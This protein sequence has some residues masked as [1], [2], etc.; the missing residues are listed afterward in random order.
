MKRLLL[1]AV[2]AAGL[3]CLL[4]APAFAGPKTFYVSPSGGNDTHN[5]QAAFNAAVAAGP[6][7][8]V[9]LTAGHFYTNTIL[10]KNFVGTFKG[11]GE[12]RTVIDCLRGLNASLKGVAVLPNTTYYPFL[13]GFEGGSVGVSDLSF[14]ITATS[15]AEPWSNGDPANPVDFLEVTVQVADNASAS[16]NHVSFAAGAGNDSG[17]NTDEGIVISGLGPYDPVTDAGTAVWVTSGTDSVRDCSFTGPPD[18]IQVM[19][20]TAGSATVEG[21]VFDD[22]AFCCLVN[23]S[24][25]SQVTIAHNQMTSAWWDDIVLWQGFQASLGAGAALPSLPAP[26]IVV[27]DN[28]MSG[29]DYAGGVEVEDDSPLY[30]APYRLDAIISGNVISLDNGGWDGGI[31]GLYARRVQVTDN[32]ISGTGLAGIDV[33]AVASIWGLHSAPDS[34]WQVIGNDVSGVT[35]TGVQY[36]GVQTAQIWLGP[37]A[38]HCLVVGGAAP[39]QVL[40]Q[41]TDDTLIHVTPVTDPPAAAA[42]PM[43]SL[44]HMKQLK[45]MMLP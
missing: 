45:G 40:D 43:H 5:L 20:L 38:D 42:T 1:V 30:N 12:G 2:L 24:S 29:T 33:G 11:A 19:G 32:R 14:D 41:G 23:D 35:S 37:Y 22:S 27:T 7:S 21:N 18:G 28:H 17:Y 9:K 16:F 44:K 6:G 39:T 36:G 26:H 10:V 4:A 3:L 8:T 34:G 31:D 25:A 15:P 13:V